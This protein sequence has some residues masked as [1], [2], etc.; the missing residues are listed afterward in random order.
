VVG[1][2]RITVLARLR[3]SPPPT[4]VIDTLNRYLEERKLH[5][6]K[7]DAAKEASGLSLAVAIDGHRSSRGES[8]LRGKLLELGEIPGEW[9]FLQFFVLAPRAT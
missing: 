2:A 6:C 5:W 4:L 7:V 8:E 1:D 3:K 9:Q